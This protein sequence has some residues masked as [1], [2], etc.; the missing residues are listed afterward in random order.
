[1]IPSIGPKMDNLC[2]LVPCLSAR[3][4]PAAFGLGQTDMQCHLE[5]GSPQWP[6]VVSELGLRRGELA[7]GT[8]RRHTCRQAETVALHMRDRDCSGDTPGRTLKLMPAAG[9]L[10]AR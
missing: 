3:H 6:L 7:A 5:M 9:L 2:L 10:V 8:C 1:M 4:D